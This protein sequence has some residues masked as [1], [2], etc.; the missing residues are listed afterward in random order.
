MRQSKCA[1]K[2]IVIPGKLAP[3]SS[4][5]NT[6]LGGAD[7]MDHFWMPVPDHGPGQAFTGMTTNEQGFVQPISF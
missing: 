3:F 4:T 7:P 2:W 1:E 5:R 6:A